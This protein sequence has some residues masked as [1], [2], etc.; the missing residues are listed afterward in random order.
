MISIVTVTEEEIACAGMLSAKGSEQKSRCLAFIRQLNNINLQHD[1]ANRF[2][3]I[4]ETKE[5]DVEKQG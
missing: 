3:D 5:R 1:K 2:A 4:T